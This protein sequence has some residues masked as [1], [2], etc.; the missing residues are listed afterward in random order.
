MAELS[1][2]GYCDTV[3]RRVAMAGGAR[4]TTCRAL[5]YRGRT[6][7]RPMLALVVLGIASFA[8]AITVPLVELTF[9]RT[10]TTATLWQAITADAGRDIPIPSI[11]L[12]IALVVA[13]VVELAALA[14]VIVPLLF[15]TR[16]PGLGRAMRA[17]DVL[18]PWR[19][20]EVFLLGVI[21][22]SVK[23][24][25]LAVARLDWGVAGNAGLAVAFAALGTFDRDALW[26]HAEEQGA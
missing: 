5:L 6:D 14:Y 8:V 16:P 21:V 9:D 3:H 15:G 17:L 13:P 7:L 25:S 10:T 19:M 20:V 12:A 2:C 22:A 26:R 18:R 24:A 1:I 11:V 23:L 4:C